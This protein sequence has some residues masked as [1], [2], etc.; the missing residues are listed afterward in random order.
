[1]S[2]TTLTYAPDPDQIIAKASRLTAE[3]Q[4]HAHPGTP[5]APSPLR[6]ESPAAQ[7]SPDPNDSSPKSPI[8]PSRSLRIKGG[9]FRLRSTSKTSEETNY[10]PPRSPG[11]LRPNTA[12]KDRNEQ[13][14]TGGGLFKSLSNEMRYL[15]KSSDESRH[16]ENYG[17]K[18]QEDPIPALNHEGLLTPSSAESPSLPSTPRLRDSTF[19][20]DHRKLKYAHPDSGKFKPRPSP[21]SSSAQY[22]RGPGQPNALPAAT[23]SSSPRLNESFNFNGRDSIKSSTTVGSSIHGNSTTTRSSAATTRTSNSEFASPQVAVF[24]PSLEEEISVDD[25][26]SLYA[27]GFEDDPTPAVNPALVVANKPAV[28]SPLSPRRNEKVPPVP[29]ITIPSIPRSSSLEITQRFPSYSTSASESP[30]KLSAASP[31]TAVSFQSSARQP[32]TSSIAPDPSHHAASSV[33]SVPAPSGRVTSAQLLAGE[34]PA[35]DHATVLMEP[36]ADPNADRYGFKKDNQYI[37]L[38]DYEAWDLH[39]RSHLDRRRH[40]W[41]ELMKQQGLNL[42][43]PSEF[44]PRSDK[45][46]R[47]IRKGIP[48]EWRGAA[49]FWYAGGPVHMNQ[50]RGL[51]QRMLERSDD[52]ASFDAGEREQAER[53]REHIERD[54]HR[55]FPDNDKFKRFPDDPNVTRPASSVSNKSATRTGFGASNLHERPMIGALRRVLRAFAF[56]QPRIGYCQ[57]LNFLAGQLLLF[58]D[59]NEEKAFHLLCILTAEH[60]PGTHGIALEGANVD[61][62]VLMGTLKDREPQLWT[63]LDDNPTDVPTSSRNSQTK[64]RPLPTVSLAT[65]SWFMS[66]FVGS[67]PVE[68]C[69]R[70]WDVLFYEGSKTL[71]RVALGIFRLGA[72]EIKRIRDPMEIFQVVQTLPRKM[73]DANMLMEASF[74]KTLE[75]R[76]LLSQDTVTKRREERREFYATER[77]ARERSASAATEATTSSASPSDATSVREREKDDRDEGKRRPS[78]SRGASLKRLM[79]S[80]SRKRQEAPPVPGIP[81]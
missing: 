56:Y 5:I 39:Y 18:L 59:G 35:D 37:S 25:Y 42:G 4:A 26:I 34:M 29:R 10:A 55:T 8:S 40:K 3:M 47:F 22:T 16:V 30:R 38:Q 45:V 15:R 66:C 31:V 48:P 28:S 13:D 68:S 12:T 23:G 65:T 9:G 76:G 57:S 70:V 71:F 33:L 58:L 81:R 2:A 64:P 1:M 53:D 63:K 62:S 46:K 74:G 50:N 24:R 21:S 41:D 11:F 19:L 36:P 72:D 73:I 51:Y 17:A 78:L 60:L 54:L 43:N 79:R 49:W 69:C 7:H 44:P 61:I 52:D 20:P 75:G 67:L 80:K 14:D 27:Q 6:F 77:L 32:S